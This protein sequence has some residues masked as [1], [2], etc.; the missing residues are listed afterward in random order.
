MQDLRRRNGRGSKRLGHELITADAQQRADESRAPAVREEH[1]LLL[2]RGSAG[3]S[4]IAHGDVA[5]DRIHRK[6]AL[7]PIG[8]SANWRVPIALF[9]QQLAERRVTFDERL[10]REHAVGRVRKAHTE[11]PV[12]ML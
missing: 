11:Q 2:A 5:G 7:D 3:Q 1:D 6:A 10:L 8:N 4:R 9:I 12:L